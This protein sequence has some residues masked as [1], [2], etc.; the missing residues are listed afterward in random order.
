MGLVA[1]E[2]MPRH[3]CPQQFPPASAGLQAVNLDHFFS[4]LNK[5]Q[6]YLMSSTWGS[7]SSPAK[8]VQF[9][10]FLA[11][12]LLQAMTTKLA[13]LQY[14]LDGPFQGSIYP[15]L[16]E[17]PSLGASLVD[18]IILFQIYKTHSPGTSCEVHTCTQFFNSSLSM[19]QGCYQAPGH[20]FLDPLQNISEG[21][22]FTNQAPIMEPGWIGPIPGTST[23]CLQ[24]LCLTPVQLRSNSSIVMNPSV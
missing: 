14:G 6:T 13:L 15:V 2:G 22:D 10:L 16:P 18:V 11:G 17:C 24:Y 23:R 3:S 4:L 8:S 20:T 21:A 9:T 7:N 19:K 5:M 12:D 1:S